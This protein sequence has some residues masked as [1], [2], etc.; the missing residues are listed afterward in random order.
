MVPLGQCGLHRL[1]S[2]LTLFSFM[3]T[4][5]GFKIELDT[6]GLQEKSIFN[7]FVVVFN[8]VANASPTLPSVIQDD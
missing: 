7:N 3:N 2:W 4:V 5:L 8:N 6:E 1:A